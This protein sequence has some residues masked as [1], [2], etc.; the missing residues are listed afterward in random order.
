GPL[1]LTRRLVLFG[2]AAQEHRPGVDALRVIAPSLIGRGV[3]ADVGITQER[4]VANAPA[5]VFRGVQPFDPAGVGVVA[6]DIQAIPPVAGK[7]APNDTPV[8]G[9]GGR[10]KGVARL[11]ADAMPPEAAHA[12]V[13][14][15]GPCPQPH[16]FRRAD[17]WR[18]RM[19]AQVPQG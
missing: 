18:L 3:A 11:D 12:Y 6:V 8:I 5:L 16:S 15:L 10:S 19:N 17:P 9:V 13:V 7:P 14:Q 1:D 4:S 2:I